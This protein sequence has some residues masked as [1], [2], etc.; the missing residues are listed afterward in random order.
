MDSQEWTIALHPKESLSDDSIVFQMQFVEATVGW[1]GEEPIESKLQG[2]EIAIRCF[3]WGELLT[4]SEME[5]ISGREMEMD[6]FDVFL[7]ALFPNP[8]RYKNQQWMYR[9]LPLPMMINANR[10]GKQFVEADWKQTSSGEWEY[11][12][13]LKMDASLE[14][15]FPL[16][17][18]GSVKGS[19]RGGS[20]WIDSHE[21]EWTRQMDIHPVEKSLIQ[22]QRFVVRVERIQ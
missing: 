19:V 20:S 17:A 8:P 13:E 3:P 6:V 16:S 2:Q 12:G 21:L 1:N 7:P 10:V 4:V 5:N 11:S 22:E 18:T 14:R 9:I 15:K